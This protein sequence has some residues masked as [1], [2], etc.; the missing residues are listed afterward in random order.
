MSG[1]VVLYNLDDSPVDAELL[2][3]MTGYQAFRGPDASCIRICGSLGMGHALLRTTFDQEHEQQPCSID[4][5]VWITGDIRLDGR[6]ELVRSLQAAG[7]RISIDDPDVLLVLHG[8]HAWE[9]RVLDRISGDF[10]FVLWDGTDQ[11]LLCARDQLGVNPL[12]Y[13]R[14][15]QTLI[16]SNTLNV[17][18]LHPGVSDQLD[19][20]SVADFLM[21][22]MNYEWGTTIFSAIKR[23]PP[24]NV[25]V[26]ENGSMRVMRYWSLPEENVY[27]HYRRKEEYVEHFLHFFRQAVD[28]R[29]RT[30][31][32]L[33]EMSGGM[34]SPSV[35]AIA[36]KLL[37]DSGRPFDFK[38]ITSIT[39]RDV[40]AKT[41]THYS[42]AAAEFIG[43]KD[44]VHLPEAEAQTPVDSPAYLPGEPA[45]VLTTEFENLANRFARNCRVT[46]TGQGGDPLFAKSSFYWRELL[47]RG[48]VIPLLQNILWHVQLH[49]SLP[50]PY[51][52]TTL[53]GQNILHRRKKPY[54]KFPEF[55]DQ[56]LTGRLKLR[57]RYLRISTETFPGGP[58]RELVASPFWTNFFASLDPGQTGLRI[59]FRHPFF[60][61]R[62][63][64]FMLSV[65]RVP[66]CFDKKL[67]RL[68]MVGLL[69]DQLLQRPKTPA[70]YISD[71]KPSQ[72]DA[73]RWML[74]LVG[75]ESLKIYVSQDRLVLAIEN[76]T[77]LNSSDYHCIPHVMGL[78]YWMRHFQ[79]PKVTR[80]SVLSASC[81]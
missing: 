6:D 26:I 75:E 29:I 68:A 20:Q 18:L 3:Q 40:P 66:W 77:Q 2:E 45:G 74:P 63:V 5:N 33:A 53:G 71:F 64:R 79:R 60:D 47:S 76:L 10:S 31:N 58:P 36:N 54:L 65:P 39:D 17:C 7:R 25:M 4:D 13:A 72:D 55:I 59:K 32:L 34:D 19:D 67:L 50:P 69:P 30:D 8:Y 46:L 15:G 57:D 23:I 21:F 81:A 41:E 80:Q 48:Q 11:K 52:R 38:V 73:S 43:L 37:R 9:H 14:A 1:F 62:L 28:D 24:A 35:V 78:A 49:H 61:L 56:N 22:G 12:F 70:G 42:L 51:L 27:L 44:H 16:I